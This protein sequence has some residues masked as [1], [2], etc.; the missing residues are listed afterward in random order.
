MILMQFIQGGMPP[1]TPYEFLFH[2]CSTKLPVVVGLKL[3]Y[4]KS[5]ISGEVMNVWWGKL[6]PKN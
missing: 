2:K 1:S 6:W 5:H 3:P 4:I